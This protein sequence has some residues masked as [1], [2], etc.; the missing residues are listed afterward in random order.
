MK[1]VARLLTVLTAVLTA[2]CD[3]PGQKVLHM[4]IYQSEQLVLRTMFGA[5]DREGTADFWRRAG[6]EPFAADAEVARVKADEDNPLRATF[7]GPVRINIMHVGRPITSASLTNL[8]LLRSTPGSLKWY[9]A[10][11]EIQRAMQ[12]AKAPVRT[13]ITYDHD[14]LRLF[15]MPLFTLVVGIFFLA[16][17][18]ALFFGLSRW[19]QPSGKIVVIASGVV[20]LLFALAIIFVLVTVATEIMG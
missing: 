17:L 7:T 8:V 16:S 9:L 5:P 13:M 1:I 2:G 20:L 10:P 4:E 15:G 14:T 19:K 6:M 12:A 3:L 11:E 18:A